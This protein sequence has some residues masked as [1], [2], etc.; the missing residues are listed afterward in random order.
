M[1]DIPGT[2]TERFTLLL[3]STYEEGDILSSSLSGVSC[4]SMQVEKRLECKNT[5]ENEYEVA[6][7]ITDSNEI[8][9]AINHYRFL[10]KYKLV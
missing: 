5:I 7:L 6:S 10:R 9:M 8:D 4:Y 3:T 1:K 2:V